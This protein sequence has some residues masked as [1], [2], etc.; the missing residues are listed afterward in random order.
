MHFK[1]ASSC[2]HSFFFFI[3]LFS[4]YSISSLASTDH[5]TL[6]SIAAVVS[7]ALSVYQDLGTPPTPTACSDGSMNCFEPRA[8]WV[9]GVPIVAAI[10]IVVV[11][12]S[13][14]DWQKEK[15][16]RKLNDKEE[17]RGVKVIRF[18][19]ETIIN[20]KDVLIDDLCLLEPGGIIPCDGVFL[21]GHNVVCDESGA[22]GVG[23][24]QE[25]LV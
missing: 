5:Q 13:V 23:C 8:D 9:E 14:N 25:I 4:F 7:F 19:H 11:V 17:D 10:L 18:G 16:F 15:Q 2:V 3:C 24:D 20:I 22:T 6:L 21:R 12:G 1:T